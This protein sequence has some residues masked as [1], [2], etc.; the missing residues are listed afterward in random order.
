MAA[1]LASA[2][3][4]TAGLQLELLQ[5]VRSALSAR[6]LRSMT[7][8]AK[9]A[10]APLPVPKSRTSMAKPPPRL[11]ARAHHCARHDGGRPRPR[12]T[13]WPPHGSLNKKGSSRLAASSPPESPN[14]QYLGDFVHRSE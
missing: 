9:V 12:P 4:A 13:S 11:A 3:F 10:R 8:A 7:V 6:P 14:F 5:R 1:L 2:D